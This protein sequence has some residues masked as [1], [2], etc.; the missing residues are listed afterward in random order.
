MRVG[1]ASITETD[2]LATHTANDQSSLKEILLI[3]Q[4]EVI[5]WATRS[6]HGCC[7]DDLV[8]PRRLMSFEPDV[9]TTCRSNM[10]RRDIGLRKDV[11]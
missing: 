11:T 8:Q 2:S 5:R 3:Y 1:R 7:H 10:R 9:T 6:S 4:H